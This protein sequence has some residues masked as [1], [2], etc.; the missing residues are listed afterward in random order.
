LSALSADPAVDPAV[1]ERIVLGRLEAIM[2]AHPERMARFLNEVELII[3]EHR[4][5]NKERTLNAR[6][7]GRRI[8]ISHVQVLRL[9]D[10]GRLGKRDSEDNPRFSEHECDAYRETERKRGRRPKVLANEGEPGV[11]S[12]QVE[13]PAASSRPGDPH[14]QN[15]HDAGVWSLVSSGRERLSGVQNT[16]VQEFQGLLDSLVGKTTGSFEGNALLAD[17]VRQMASSH[18]IAFAYQGTPVR[19]VCLNPETSSFQLRSAVGKDSY[20]ASSK[21]WPQLKAVSLSEIPK[22][23]RKNARKLGGDL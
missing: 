3:E 7:A 5:A 21:A 20:V 16:L 6:Q 15:V 10:A 19:V 18:G 4:P 12:V 2:K 1:E 17:E 14:H 22:P 11:S 23:P 9:L 8:G 13:G